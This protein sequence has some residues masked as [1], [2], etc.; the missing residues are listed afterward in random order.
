MQTV[1]VQI[2]YKDGIG[3][4]QN[5]AEKHLICIAKPTVNSLS[6][7]VQPASVK[8]FKDWIKQAENTNTITLK[9]AKKKWT[10]KRK[11]FT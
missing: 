11:Q 4:L 9:E 3:A 1:T 7:P 5:L 8:E 6:L 2:T 10:A